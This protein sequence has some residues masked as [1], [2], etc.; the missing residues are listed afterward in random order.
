MSAGRRSYRRSTSGVVSQPLGIV[1][2]DARAT[3]NP[4]GLRLALPAPLAKS[5]QPTPQL[6]QPLPR[7][8]HPRLRGMGVGIAACLDHVQD[9]GM[10]RGGSQAP[11]ENNFYSGLTRVKTRGLLGS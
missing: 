7:D 6:M 4:S 2:R 5:G 10:T 9:Y 1:P 8:E 3:A 11:S